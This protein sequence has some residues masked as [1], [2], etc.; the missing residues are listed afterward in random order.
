MTLSIISFLLNILTVIIS[1]KKR[2]IVYATSIF[3]FLSLVSGQSLQL[4][5]DLTE[6]PDVQ[7]LHHFIN[8]AGFDNS[9]LYLLLTSVLLLIIPI[10][11]SSHR[12]KIFRDAVGYRLSLFKTVLMYFLILLNIFTLI[13]LIVGWSL[14][15]SSTRPGVVTGSTIFLVILSLGIYPA[16]NQVI[17]R[18]RIK[19]RFIVLL[20]LVLVVT[21]L[22]S[23]IH[24]I[25]YGL[26]FFVA[27]FYSSG[28]NR[29]KVSLKELFNIL[30]FG[31][32][33]LS[34]FLLIGTIRDTLNFV[35]GGWNE[36]IQYAIDNIDSGILSI[37]YNYI[38]SVEGMSGLAGAF[39]YLDEQGEQ[40]FDMGL[41]VFV[42][43]LF[44]WIPG[45]LKPYTAPYIEEIVA[46]NWYQKSIVP[47]GFESSFVSFGWFGIFLFPLMLYFISNFLTMVY[48]KSLNINIKI[49]SLIMIGMQV[50]FIRGSWQVWVAYSISYLFIFGLYKLFFN[51][52]YQ[53]H[54]GYKN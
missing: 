50:F 45:F 36:V 42:Q 14:F 6:Y 48:I 28:I 5:F 30:V 33:F 39:T 20:L 37:R 44:Q 12:G 10:L 26:I 16:L 25:V 27:W 18:E 47:S 40:T 24:V 52:S 15:I 38:A 9:L 49:V 54:W 21:L 13:F 23:R 22:F 34:I 43:G 17:C 35:N 29:K 2:M 3:F 19:W 32:L 7:Y 4:A 53:L 11:F 31:M 41:S 51:S 1:Y 46:S 8:T